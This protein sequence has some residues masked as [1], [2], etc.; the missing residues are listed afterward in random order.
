MLRLFRKF[1]AVFL[2]IWLPL[3]GGNVLAMT[4][5][6]PNSGEASHTSVVKAELT[7]AS[8]HHHLTVAMDHC[9]AQDES[10]NSNTQSDT[11]CKHPAACQLAVAAG[12]I[13]VDLPASALHATPYLTLFQSQ[14]VAPLDPPPLTRA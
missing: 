1:I 9:A 6:M 2:A 4:V 14:S 8:S 7:H 12:Q 11:G 5:S 10:T 13:N 3:N